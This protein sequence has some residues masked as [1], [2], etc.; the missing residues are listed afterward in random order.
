MMT[1][2]SIEVGGAATPPGFTL[3]SLNGTAITI[4]QSTPTPPIEM[5]V[6]RLAARFGL[7][8]VRA[9][10]IAELAGIGGRT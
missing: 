1:S 4:Y 2:S 8:L 10:V 5:A 7:P 9:R 3:A 6:L